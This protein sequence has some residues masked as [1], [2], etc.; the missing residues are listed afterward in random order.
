[1]RNK[2]SYKIYIWRL[3]AYSPYPP[4]GTFPR[5]GKGL[6]KQFFAPGNRCFAI[7]AMLS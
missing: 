5:E 1:M 3:L 7:F 4:T 6:R 2:F